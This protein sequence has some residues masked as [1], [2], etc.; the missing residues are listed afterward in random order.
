MVGMAG[1]STHSRSTPAGKR[2]QRRADRRRARLQVWLLVCGGAL[3]FAGLLFW[4]L[5]PKGNSLGPA[6]VGEPAGD[7]VLA[8]LNGRPVHLSDYQ[9]QV[10]LINGWATW[11]PPC[12]A[13]MPTLQAFYEAHREQ[14][15]SLL[16]VNAGEGQP[17]VTGFVSQMGFTF[18]VLLD[19]GER[20]LSGLGTAGLPTS[21]VIGRDGMVKYIHAGGIT[22][23]VL[24]GAGRSTP[25]RPIGLCRLAAK[26]RLL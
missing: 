3:V 14:G 11:C 2:A 16:A 24:E 5:S 22:G 8:D 1:M 10:V 25:G 7:F 26:T 17:A 13:E 21:F 4:S 6:R 18:P 19:P 20:V 23:D 9:G 15:F 12:R